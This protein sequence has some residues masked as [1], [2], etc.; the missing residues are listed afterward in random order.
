MDQLQGTPLLPGLHGS[1]FLSAFDAWTA[2]KQL[3]EVGMPIKTE[4]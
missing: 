2:L 4:Q 3:P 1:V